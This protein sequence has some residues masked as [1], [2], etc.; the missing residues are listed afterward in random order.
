[1]V[2]FRYIQEPNIIL[3]I[4][5]ADVDLA[6]SD[7]IK[8]SRKADPQ[9][10]RT[11]GV[12]TKMDQIR[13][14]DGAEL[15]K[16]NDYRLG[17]GYIGVINKP[18]TAGAHFEDA[19]KYFSNES[20]YLDILDRVGVSNLRNKLV[21]ILEEHMIRSLMLMAERVKTELDDTKYVLKVDYND[22]RISQDYYIANMATVIKAQF[23]EFAHNFGKV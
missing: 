12:L 2:H 22:R 14:T 13:A 20:A 1:M 9:C 3:A 23:Y 4:S 11:L 21:K 19:D 10:T 15:L 17:L 16:H 6:N 8:E 5:S 18:P 7:S